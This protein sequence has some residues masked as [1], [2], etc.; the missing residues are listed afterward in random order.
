MVTLVRVLPRMLV[1][2][3]LQAVRW[4]RVSLQPRRCISEPALASLEGRKL[5]NAVFYLDCR[6]CDCYCCC[7]NYLRRESFSEPVCL[8]ETS[9]HLEVILIEIMA[10]SYSILQKPTPKLPKDNQSIEDIKFVEEHGYILFP[11]LLDPQLVQD[12]LAEIDR[13]TAPDALSGRNSFEGTNTNRIYSLL[14]KSR[15]FDPFTIISRIL[16]LNDYFLDDGYQITSFH[17]IQINP[18]EK[19]QELHHDDA[20]CHFPRPRGP[21]GTAIMVALDEF[22]AVSP[23]RDRNME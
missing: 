4:R 9:E 12:A 14:N 10:P 19:G 20:F 13:M 16:A 22:T 23:I 2:A 21:L 18:G 7:E 1:G 3:S 17:T 11:S 5:Q 15:V 6:S 8:Q